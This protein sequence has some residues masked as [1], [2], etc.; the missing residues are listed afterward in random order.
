[1]TTSRSTHLLLVLAAFL[2]GLGLFLGALWYAT[3]NFGNNAVSSASAVGGPFKLVNQN[4]QPITD[5]D[6]KGKPLLIFF[7]FTHC[8]D[9]CPTTLFEVSEMFRALGKDADRVNALFISVDPE[10]DTPALMK[11]YLSSFDPH[12]MAATGDRAAVDVAI[13]AYRVYAKK[14]PTKGDDYTMDHTAIVYLMDK[15]GRFVAPFNLKR[16]PAEA[17][18]DLRKFL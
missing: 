7:G 10:R 12:L 1:M 5:E 14:I 15:Q 2:T 6:F 17:A 4:G 16:S 9:V 11:D 3:G 18:A 8:P 13:K